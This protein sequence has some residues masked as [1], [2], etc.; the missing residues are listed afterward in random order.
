M[1]GLRIPIQMSGYD[2]VVLNPSGY[3]DPCT[4][5]IASYDLKLSI[6]N[7]EDILN[8]R[9]IGYH[10]QYRAQAPL[11]Q[12]T[13]DEYESLCY[14][15]GA[16]VDKFH[17]IPVIIGC[18][19]GATPAIAS[20]HFRQIVKD[21]LNSSIRTTGNAQ[22]NPPPPPRLNDIRVQEEDGCS[23]DSLLNGCQCGFAE[24]ERNGKG[25]N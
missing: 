4:S 8:D 16:L 21:E 20:E 23:C 3:F 25:N 19:G 1:A 5:S 17:N 10:R 11:L 15:L 2:K 13:R 9:V 18:L 14:Y 22:G 6:L 24:R 12:L 7:I